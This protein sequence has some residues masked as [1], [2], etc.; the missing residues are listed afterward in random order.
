MKRRNQLSSSISVLFL[1]FIA[2]LNI[3]REPRFTSIRAVDVV[4]LIAIGMCFGVA[5]IGLVGVVRDSR[6][7]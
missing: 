1:G 4:Q 3:A 7:G 6:S 2:L 5:L